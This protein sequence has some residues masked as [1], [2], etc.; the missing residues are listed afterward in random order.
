MQAGGLLNGC[1]YTKRQEIYVCVERERDRKRDTTLW[2]FREKSLLPLLVLEQIGIRSTRK[3]RYYVSNRCSFK[4]GSRETGLDAHGC[5]KRYPGVHEYICSHTDVNKP[6]ANPFGNSFMSYKL[7]C[8][9]QVDNDSCVKKS[10]EWL[11]FTGSS[12]QCRGGK[13]RQT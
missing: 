2:L 11:L 12:C 1:K 4:N 8:Y 6:R 3:P 13:E 10:T 7:G 5:W 9:T